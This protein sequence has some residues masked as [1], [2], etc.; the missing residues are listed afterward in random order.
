MVNIKQTKIVQFIFHLISPVTGFFKEMYSATKGKTLAV[1]W[2]IALFF[3]V[4]VLT[5]YYFVVFANHYSLG[6]DMSNISSN[7]HI[8]FKVTKQ[9]AGYDDLQKGQYIMFKTD[10]MEPFVSKDAAIIKKVVGLEGDHVQV[11]GLEVF[12]NGKK[13]GEM[14]VEALKKLNKTPKQLSRDYILP[15]N[16]AF[17]MG[18][19]ERSFDSRYW[20]YLQ[21][22]DTDKLN[23]A[24]PLWF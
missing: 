1:L 16:T 18:S 9:S 19:Y 6:V 10:K 5:K 17:V 21:F 11:K 24:T 13:L 2:V 4:V 15:E 8:F 7:D 20:D 14:H 12:V 22:Q 3:G 23:I